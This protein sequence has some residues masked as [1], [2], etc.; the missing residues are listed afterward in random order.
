[1]EGYKWEIGE[2][3]TET[4]DAEMGYR[5]WKHKKNEKSE[6]RHRPAQQNAHVACKNNMICLHHLIMITKIEVSV[7][8]THFLLGVR[9]FAPTVATKI[10]TLQ[11]VSQYFSKDVLDLMSVQS[12]RTKD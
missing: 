12:C 10:E 2:T 3:E 6:A 11:K 5:K 7:K 4:G 8:K 1:M 9:L